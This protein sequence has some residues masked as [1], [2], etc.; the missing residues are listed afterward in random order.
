VTF[1][2]GFEDDVDEV[3]EE[4]QNEA[5]RIAQEAEVAVI[6]AGLPDNFESEGY[7]RKHLNLPNC[8]NA[9][10]EKICNVQKNTLCCITDLR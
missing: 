4:L 6:F 10:I 1:A 8:Q 5:V 3:N 7:D 9:L 2:G